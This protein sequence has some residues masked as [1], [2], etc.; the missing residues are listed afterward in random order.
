MLVHKISDE[1]K[2]S[3]L[4]RCIG[5]QKNFR[6][7]DSVHN[8]WF[9]E[10]NMFYFFPKKISRRTGCGNL[11]KGGLY[12]RQIKCNLRLNCEIVV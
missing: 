1:A 9:M 2:R 10:E 6:K 12:K 5:L 4:E 11:A 3:S 7:T 8:I